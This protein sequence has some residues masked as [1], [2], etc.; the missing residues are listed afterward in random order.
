MSVALD[1]AQAKALQ[2]SLDQLIQHL[3]E[4]AASPAGQK[5][6]PHPATEHHYQ[7]EV[8]FELFGNP[9]NNHPLPKVLSVNFGEQEA[10]V[11]INPNQPLD[12]QLERLAL[13]LS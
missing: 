13:S 10:G 6:T 7:G 9:Q 2:Q 11:W 1:L 3:K 4:V 5:K 12:L 8:Y